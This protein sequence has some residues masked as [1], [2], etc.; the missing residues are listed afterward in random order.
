MDI[1]ALLA[2]TNLFV[3][4][5]GPALDQLAAR[6]EIV[7]VASGETLLEIGT[8]A[9]CF[10]IVAVGRLRVVLGDGIVVNEV[11]R[12]EPIGEI[13]LLSGE[14][15]SATVYA[16][17]DS[18]VL[19]IGREA[20][21]EVFQ[22][23]PSALLEMS[24]M[25][26]MRLRQNQRAAT[27]ASVRRSRCFA[28]LPATPQV[29]LR[30]FT[31]AL[32]A[33]L[34]PCGDVELLDAETVDAALGAGRAQTAVG[35]EEREE[36]LIDWL[37]EREMAHRHLIYVA[38]SNSCNWSRRCLRQA[39]RVLVLADSAH[40]PSQSPMMDDLRRSAV[41][42]PIDLVLTRPEPAAAGRVL[43]WRQNVGAAAHYFVRPG[44]A[45]DVD[46]IARSL[47]GRAIGLVL[48]GGGAR[49]FAHI[50]L[51]RALE[52][53]GTEIDLIGGT[54]MGAFIS[55]LAAC[56][57]DS[58]EMLRITRETFVSRN[59]LND[60]LF[61]SVSLIRGRKFL[62]R[63][64]DIFG[65][66]QIEDLR[67]PYF[68]VSTNL[69][70]GCSVAHDRGPLSTW[71]GTS[72]CI[73]GVAPPVAYKGDLLVDGAVINSLPTDVMQALERGPIIASDVSTEGG[74]SAAGIEGPDPEGLLSWKMTAKR[75]SLIS[76]LF[77][78]AT[79][80]SESGTA[81][82]AAR[83]D[84]YLRM[85]VNGIAMFD[86]KKLDEVADR[87]YRAAMEHLPGFHTS[88]ANVCPL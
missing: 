25:V 39:D 14:P 68:C 74:I 58:G 34:R 11:G 23:H 33:A 30:G 32:A 4:L 50:G 40:A 12:L 44:N 18:K 87:G 86:W 76:I 60:Y 20:L 54:S 49:G 29:D 66:R 35:D 61:P 64:R 28:V 5:S 17:R 7:E 84:L 10:Y 41:R 43:E 37:Q 65:E 2:Q 6:C 51:I 24:R 77:R 62:N 79:L 78:T 9:E 47:T 19:K 85:P 80:T 36:G 16:V 56:G 83:A 52:E 22:R 15:R 59:L 27:L 26:I 21:Y 13:S 71:I 48:G 63:L 38:G 3:A 81:A 67:T 42:T 8:A 53:T 70:R 46:R 73:P 31:R 45:R 88:T 72:M 82:R 55:G 69:T 1:R 75:P 57:Y